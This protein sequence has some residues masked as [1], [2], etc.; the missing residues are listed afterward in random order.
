MLAT[1]APRVCWVQPVAYTRYCSMSM[2][3]EEHFQ[4][5]LVGH[6]EA[7]SR[8]Y[9]QHVQRALGRMY[10]SGYP[11]RILAVAMTAL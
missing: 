1:R 6:W 4:S 5:G 3:V 7:L 10:P 2:W 8:M 9:W 11:C